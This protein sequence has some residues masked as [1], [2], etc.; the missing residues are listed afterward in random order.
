MIN[1]PSGIGGAAGGGG[2]GGRSTDGGGGGAGRSGYFVRGSFTNSK[3]N[4]IT[5][6]E[7]MEGRVEVVEQAAVPFP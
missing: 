2:G 7:A 3:K 1:I 5:H 6:L 4:R